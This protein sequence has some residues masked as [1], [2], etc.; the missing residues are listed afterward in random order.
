MSVIEEHVR[1]I[2]IELG[3]DPD[4]NPSLKDTPRR[5]A[6]MLRELTAKDPD[7]DRMVLFDVEG[8][9]DITIER[10]IPYFTLC[11]HH[12]LPFYGTVTIAYLTKGRIFGVSKL[13]RIVRK[14]SKGLNT[15]EVMTHRIA[16]DVYKALDNNEDSGVMVISTGIHMCQIMRGVKTSGQVI[17]SAIRGVMMDPKVKSEVLSLVNLNDGSRY[18]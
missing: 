7:D 18:T 12:L 6:E 9:N 3:Y 5:V 10:D 14:N 2:L 16:D 15:Q 13:A 4:T 17:A 11:E 1:A 8:Y